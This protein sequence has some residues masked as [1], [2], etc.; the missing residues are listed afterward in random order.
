[1]NLP[2]QRNIES[3]RIEEE[4]F[5]NEELNEIDNSFD[6]SY[7]KMMKKL[8]Q[9][10]SNK[11]QV[12]SPRSQSLY[13]RIHSTRIQPKKLE[14]IEQY[15]EEEV[16]DLNYSRLEYQELSDGNSSNDDEILDSDEMDSEG[17][18]DDDQ[19]EQPITQLGVS[20]KQEEDP[21]LTIFSKSLQNRFEALKAL[22]QATEEPDIDDI[23]D[24]F[25]MDTED[26]FVDDQK[27][28]EVPTK[29]VDPGI[30]FNESLKRRLEEAKAL[31]DRTK[32]H[33]YLS[34]NEM[35][36]EDLFNESLKLVKNLYSEQANQTPKDNKITEYDRELN[37]ENYE[38]S[39]DDEHLKSYELDELFQYEDED[40]APVPVRDIPTPIASTSQRRH[41]NVL[42][43][44][45]PRPQRTQLKPLLDSFDL[46]D[47]SLPDELL[48]LTQESLESILGDHEMDIGDLFAD[49]NVMAPRDVISPEKMAVRTSVAQ[50]IK[51]RE[52]KRKIR[53][54]RGEEE[55]PEEPDAQNKALQRLMEEDL[56]YPTKF[57]NFIE[58]KTLLDRTLDTITLSP[59]LI[60]S[61]QKTKY[62]PFAEYEEDVDEHYNYV[63][64]QNVSKHE[65]FQSYEINEL[66]GYEDEGEDP[67]QL[68]EIPIVQRTPS[69]KKRRVNHLGKITP[70]TRTPLGYNFG[71]E[72]N[73]ADESMPKDL[74]ESPIPS[75]PTNALMQSIAKSST[76]KDLKNQMRRRR[77]ET[78]MPE[79][80][81]V[82]QEIENRLAVEELIAQSDVIENLPAPQQ[83]KILSEFE[84]D[85]DDYYNI[86]S[87]DDHLEQY[88]I[89][90][91]IGYDDEMEEPFNLGDIPM[92]QKPVTPK[93]LRIDYLSKTQ[94]L[95]AKE[96]RRIYVGS[97]SEL[98][99]ESIDL[100]E[101]VSS[102]QS[103]LN[104]NEMNISDMF[105]DEN[106]LNPRNFK[107]PKKMAI[108]MSKIQTSKTRYLINRFRE[109]KGEAIIETP[110]FQE[111]IP[112]SV[113]LAEYQRILEAD[114]ILNF[115]SPVPQGANAMIEFDRDLNEYYQSDEKQE[116]LPSFEVDEL[117]GYDEEG[118]EPLPLSQIPIKSPKQKTPS[119]KKRET[120]KPP[121]YFDHP[122]DEDFVNPEEMEYLF[123]DEA[124]EF[125]RPVA[126]RKIP[127]SL[128]KR[129]RNREYLSFLGEPKRTPL[130]VVIGDDDLDMEEAPSFVDLFVG[131]KTAPVKYS[132]ADKSFG[133][134]N[135]QESGSSK[136]PAFLDVFVGEKKTPVKY[137]HL[138]GPEILSL[139]NRL[140]KIK[141]KTPIKDHSYSPIKS[142]E[143]FQASTPLTGIQKAKDYL[144]FKDDIGSPVKHL[145][146]ISPPKSFER[147]F[148]GTSPLK[149]NARRRL[150]SQ[151]KIPSEEH[152][153]SKQDK[154]TDR[155][156][157]IAEASPAHLDEQNLDSDYSGEEVKD[158]KT[159]PANNKP[160]RTR[161]RTKALYNLTDDEE[162]NE[163][164]EEL[165]DL[166]YSQSE[167]DFAWLDNF[168]PTTPSPVKHKNTKKLEPRVAALTKR[169]D[170]QRKMVEMKRVP[171]K[172][173][174]PVK[175]SVPV[176]KKLIKK[177]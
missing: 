14:F 72:R 33:S 2:K 110:K 160:P 89:D 170:D 144:Q 164:D 37:E 138:P 93:K 92:P 172:K 134:E 20:T 119:P 128:P 140:E 57:K 87:L 159:I 98:E 15:P 129:F 167:M 101:S 70:M 50:T 26:L 118:E 108:E 22:G 150:F 47:E 91:L 29:K 165:S 103:L 171:V 85:L 130:P 123:G 111:N 7:K 60:R 120:Q 102:Q 51:F 49:S 81:T 80:A 139:K 177:R 9:E 27:E 121:R 23:L 66:F 168:R 40:E 156:K 141:T 68:R 46:A 39:A 154:L 162:V 36:L 114:E 176:K 16:V 6:R 74:D 116:H 56:M 99:D 35:D 73:I 83:I 166:E 135:L 169:K 75:T 148:A 28:L 137:V 174:V 84:K 122:S 146:F 117:A 125:A 77:G 48:Q 1:M 53:I 133:L 147:S 3:T 86:G 41:I 25:E 157:E 97:D 63:Q 78:P 106:L 126:V 145:D 43:K 18:F 127:I 100:E 34:D 71:T 8:H 31:N 149:S 153:T 69:P 132:R 107:S 45:G 90:E 21:N 61:P 13:D 44:P 10:K 5:K 4:L 42:E 82:I 65:H 19:L 64:K 109:Q 32:D 151:S 59:P 152:T 12:L 105:A 58:T 175:K 24:S 88:E 158:N 115:K 94:P 62:Q 38:S 79:E 104:E 55:I 113:A 136:V 17:L 163:E 52:L 155:F 143:P 142:N 173:A 112:D 76:L 161:T 54:K 131:N 67:V 95:P 30:T 96:P 11:S 124:D